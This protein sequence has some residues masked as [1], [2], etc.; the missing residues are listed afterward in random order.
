MN[1]RYFPVA[2]HLRIFSAAGF[3]YI[4]GRIDTPPTYSTLVLA[5]TSFAASIAGWT[6][7]RPIMREAKRH[8]TLACASKSKPGDSDDAD[9]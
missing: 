9:S 8:I 4:V 5:C 3:G 2:L 7:M 1:L 6:M